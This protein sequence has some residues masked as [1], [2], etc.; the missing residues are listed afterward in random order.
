MDV[1]TLTILATVLAAAAGQTCGT[2]S[3]CGLLFVSAAIDDYQAYTNGDF[4]FADET[5]ISK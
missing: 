3:R 2:Y 5:I 1:K 4:E